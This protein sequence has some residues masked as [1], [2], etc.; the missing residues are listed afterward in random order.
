MTGGGRGGKP[1][2]CSPPL[3]WRRTK[4]EKKNPKCQYQHLKLLK[5]FFYPKFSR[6]ISKTGLKQLK[7]KQIPHPTPWKN[8]GIQY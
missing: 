8:V 5:L 2:I 4:I 6:A 3:F 7:H 1:G